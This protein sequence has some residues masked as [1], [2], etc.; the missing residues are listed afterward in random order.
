MSDIEEVADVFKAL[1]SP[2]RLRILEMVSETKRPLHIKGIARQLNL[3]YASVHRHVSNLRK[4]GLVE[5]YEVGRSRVLSVSKQKEI[6]RIIQLSSQLTGKQ[7]V[8]S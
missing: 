2:V 1:A 5:V 4:F 3:D 7:A 6:T 8:D